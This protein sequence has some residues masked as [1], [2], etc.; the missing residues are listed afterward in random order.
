M[1][2]DQPIWKEIVPPLLV[3]L[4]GFVTGVFL[5]FASGR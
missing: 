5:C 3:F 1:N 2:D 4:A